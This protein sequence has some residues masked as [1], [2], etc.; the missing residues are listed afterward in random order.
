MAPPLPDD[1]A[2]KTTD[3]AADADA[4]TLAGEQQLRLDAEL[5]QEWPALST[6]RQFLLVLAMTLAMMLNVRF[7]PSSSL[8]KVPAR[9]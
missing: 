7:S 9:H 4:K 1:A 3:S 6:A 2:D 5:A 8:P